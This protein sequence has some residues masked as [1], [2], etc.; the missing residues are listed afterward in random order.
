MHKP[1]Q[2]WH[3]LIEVTAS[4]LTGGVVVL[5]LLATQRENL[6]LS[7]NYATRRQVLQYIGT[8]VRGA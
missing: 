2:L 5:M 4:A 6:E 8:R 7:I 3:G 1:D